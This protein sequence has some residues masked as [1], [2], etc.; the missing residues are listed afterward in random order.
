M[1]SDRSL[2]RPPLMKKRLLPLY[3]LTTCCLAGLAMAQPAP[4]RPGQGRQDA[5]PPAPPAQQPNQRR[6]DARPAAPPQ[7][8]QDAAQ[9]SSR[10]SPEERKELRQQIH[11]AGHDL[12]P[13]KRTAP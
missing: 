10:L 2:N 6:D 5:A 9:R 3:L 8:A 13:R 11:E 7:P 12:Y 4:S 1:A